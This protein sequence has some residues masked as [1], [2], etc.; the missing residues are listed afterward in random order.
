MP[1]INLIASSNPENGAV[2]ISPDGSEFSI[3][4]DTPL[5]IPQSDEIYISVD[6]S[7]IWWTVA[8]V[9]ENVNNK[10]YISNLDT[11]TFNI[12]EIPQGLYD[13]NN[14][15]GAIDRALTQQGVQTDPPLI[16]LVPDS[17]TQKVV[18]EGNGTTNLQIDFTYPDTLREI[19]GFDSQIYNILLPVLAPNVARFNTVNSFLLH[20][21][22]CNNGI[23]LNG[24]YNQTIAQ[25][26][27]NVPAGSQIIY[28]PFRPSRIFAP[29]LSD[30]NITTIRFW[31]TNEKNQPVNTSGEYF[32]LKLR[33]EY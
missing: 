14:L 11:G 31:L 25:V 23:K 1:E 29:E 15:N 2:N 22:L 7:F 21:D 24:L 18:I 17:A 3:I 6:Q 13:L 19:L 10:L 16:T 8:N 30:R 28:E 4:L 12:L 33:I 5:K 32:S 9:I 20:T 26:L 27:I